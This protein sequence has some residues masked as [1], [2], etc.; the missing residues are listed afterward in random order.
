MPPRRLLA[1]T[2]SPSRAEFQA[3]GLVALSCCRLGGLQPDDRILDIGSGVGRVAFPLTGYLS[4][5]G[6]YAGVDMWREGI[7]WCRRAITRPFPNFTFQHLDAYHSTYN[8]SGTTP[9][10]ALRLPEDDGSFDFVLIGA[11]NHLETRELLAFVSE[12]GR[13]LRPGGTYLGTWFL[14]DDESAQGVLPSGAAGVAC[15]E[16]VMRAA[17]SAAS[18]QLEVLHPGAWRATPDAPSYQDLV[19]ARRSAD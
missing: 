1:R 11:I 18:L 7:Q 5:A 15:Q 3:A 6:S 10:T 9:I 19:V 17:L 13:V 16:S 14:V 12:A 2:S 8:P 4:A